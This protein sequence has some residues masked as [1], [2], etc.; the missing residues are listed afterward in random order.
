MISKGGVICKY[1]VSNLPSTFD[2]LTSE[3][4][5]TAATAI[6]GSDPLGIGLLIAICVLSITILCL[7]F[8]VYKEVIKTKAKVDVLEEKVLRLEKNGSEWIKL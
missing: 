2:M 3:D 6:N 5:I 4:K 8:I 7:M 1:P